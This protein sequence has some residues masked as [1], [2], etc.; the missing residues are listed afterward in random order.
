MNDECEGD[1][2]KEQVVGLENK[3][4]VFSHFFSW[5]ETGKRTTE[6]PKKYS[7][8]IRVYPVYPSRDKRGLSQKDWHGAISKS[9]AG[10]L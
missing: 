9:T 4:S 2:M 1:W 8:V 5:C 3:N 7:H 6:G 10:L